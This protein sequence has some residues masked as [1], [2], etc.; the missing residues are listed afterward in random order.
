MTAALL[1]PRLTVAQVATIL[2]RSR[3]WVRQAANDAVIP[4]EKV[5]HLWRFNPDDL[6]V[7][8]ASKRNRPAMTMTALSAKRQA[9]KH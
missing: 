8:L 1:T 6:E 4:A 9:K 5:G 3:A 7:W 2:G